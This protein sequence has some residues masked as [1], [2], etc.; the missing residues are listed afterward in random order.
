MGKKKLTEWLTDEQGWFWVD[1][2]TRAPQKVIWQKEGRKSGV[3]AS[4]L[5]LTSL[6]RKFLA[7]QQ[8]VLARMKVPHP[9][10]TGTLQ[11]GAFKDIHVAF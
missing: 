6:I 1:F 2:V 9:V 7:Q 11:R 8:A 5:K 4:D 3:I 10:F